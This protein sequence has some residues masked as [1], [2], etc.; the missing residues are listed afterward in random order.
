MQQSK[1]VT[2][3]HSPILFR[4]PSRFGHRRPLSKVPCAAQQVLVSYLRY[5]YCVCVNSNIVYFLKMEN[6]EKTIVSLYIIYAK[7]KH[8]KLLQSLFL[9]LITRWVDSYGFSIERFS[10]S[11]HR[12]AS[13]KPGW[14]QNFWTE[15]PNK[16]NSITIYKYQK[17]KYSP[18]N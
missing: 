17:Q 18:I 2:D 11:V 16:I 5:H 6:R 9:K 15:G 1:S 10:H 8:A 4:F 3:T 7:R 14:I 13:P 12:T